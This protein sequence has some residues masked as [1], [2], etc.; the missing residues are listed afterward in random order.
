MTITTMRL[1]VP[2]AIAF[3]LAVVGVAAAAIPTPVNGQITDAVAR[4]DANQNGGL[5]R[6]EWR[7]AGVKTFAAVDSDE[8][9]L[10]SGD[11]FAV[12]HGA[13]FAAIDVD[14]DG[15]MTPAE[16]DAYKRLPWTLN[17]SR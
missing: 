7:R 17:V 9:G 5:D 11:E 10:I 3:A 13:M 16:L 8:D 1:I 6:D 2:A 12:L 14:H 4:L 15:R